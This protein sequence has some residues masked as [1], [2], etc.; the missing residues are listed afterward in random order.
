MNGVGRDDEDR[1]F[2]RL[3]RLPLFKKQHR[4]KVGPNASEHGSADRSIAFRGR[5]QSGKAAAPGIASM[6][7]LHSVENC[8]M[9]TPRAKVQKGRAFFSRRLLPCAYPVYRIAMRDHVFRQLKLQQILRGVP[10]RN[11]LMHQYNGAFERCL[12]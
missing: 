10:Q 2:L 5:R 11:R 6:E 4:R 7:L 9:L 8:A 12:G 3:R 1:R